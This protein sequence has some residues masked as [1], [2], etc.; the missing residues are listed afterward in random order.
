MKNKFL[1]VT[2]LAVLISS[3]SKQVKNNKILDGDWIVKTYKDSY[4]QQTET[5]NYPVVYQFEKK[6][7]LEGNLTIT[8]TPNTTN[9]TT[10]SKWTYFMKK[11]GGD[12]I[13]ILENSSYLGVINKL[14]KSELIL[15]GNSGSTFTLSKQ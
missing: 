6:S 11:D 14:D 9:T 2:V 4:S 3:C 12:T 13:F 10:V 7:K 15:E 1:T 8:S 5:L